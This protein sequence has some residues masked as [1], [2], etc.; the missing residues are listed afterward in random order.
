MRKGPTAETHDFQPASPS[1]SPQGAARP[2]EDNAMGPCLMARQF[3][4]L[5]SAVCELMTA[6]SPLRSPNPS[7]HLAISL[8]FLRLPVV[9]HI[10]TRLLTKD[11]LSIRP[12]R[13]KTDL[14][15][16]RPAAVRNL[17]CMEYLTQVNLFS[18]AHTAG[19]PSHIYQSRGHVL[20]LKSINVFYGS[21]GA[22]ND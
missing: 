11:N 1:P 5:E 8:P 6:L 4:V 19:P 3:P 10:K 22:R 13:S 12:C 18:R 9:C 17:R 16:G 2:H 20:N 15:G 7:P 21:T 14:S